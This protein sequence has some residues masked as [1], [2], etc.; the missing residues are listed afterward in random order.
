MI[1]DDF[2]DFD[3]SIE[4][5]ARRRASTRLETSRRARIT[6]LRRSVLLASP[7]LVRVRVHVRNE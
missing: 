1:F 6:D 2:D 7:V 5:A 4:S 3:D